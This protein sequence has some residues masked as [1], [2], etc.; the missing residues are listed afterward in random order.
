[1]QGIYIIRCDQDL[2]VYIGSSLNIEDRWRHH[3][4]LLNKNKHHN[5]KLQRA[6]N[7][8]GDESFVFEIL[9]ETSNLQEKEQYYLDTVWPN[10]Y[11]ICRYVENAWSSKNKEL[12]LARRFEKRQSYGTGNTLKE[13]E[14]I[15]IIDRLNSGE[16]HKSIA[17]DYGI[18]VNSV[19]NI[20]TGATWTYLNYLVDNKDSDNKNKR[21]QSKKE[22]FYYFDEGKSKKEVMKLTGRSKA[23]VW[24]YHQEYLTKSMG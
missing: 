9:E 7:A 16:L 20:K 17:S 13:N 1:M 8:Y 3:K 21:T 22:A 11:N 14:V 23:T 18:E 2:E 10:C 24:R 19:S 12:M 5:Y 4:Y 6:W 15:E